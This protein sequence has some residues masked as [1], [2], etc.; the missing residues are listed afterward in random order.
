MEG[1]GKEDIEGRYLEK[2]IWKKR[3]RKEERYFRNEFE[4]F[5]DL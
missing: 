3:K 1:S 2:N 4:K 5:D